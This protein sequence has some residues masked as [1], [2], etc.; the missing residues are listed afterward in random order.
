MT[1]N[2]RMRLFECIGLIDDSFVEEVESFQYEYLPSPNRKKMIKYG[3]AAGVMMTLA[4]AA[5]YL[6]LRGRARNA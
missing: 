5:V 4:A 6:G 1:S 2:Y 3:T